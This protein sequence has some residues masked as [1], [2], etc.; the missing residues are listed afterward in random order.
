MTE[1]VAN[2]PW[3]GQQV[4]INR[5]TKAVVAPAGFPLAQFKVD[6]FQVVTLK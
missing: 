2:D 5:S 6:G 3:T 4:R 1:I